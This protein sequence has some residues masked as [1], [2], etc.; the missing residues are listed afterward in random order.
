[1]GRGGGGGVKEKERS[2]VEV[3]NFFSL[4]LF[5]SPIHHFFF[6]AVSLSGPW[7]VF[8]LFKEAAESK[9]LLVLAFSRR[10]KSVRSI[11]ERGSR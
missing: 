10:K 11:K 4:S 6:T 3:E 8:F 7:R 5:T 2:R 1:M 9:K